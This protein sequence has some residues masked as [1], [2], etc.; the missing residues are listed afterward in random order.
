MTVAVVQEGGLG[1][2]QRDLSGVEH[3]EGSL[4]EVAFNPNWKKNGVEGRPQKVAG[5]GLSI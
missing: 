1:W 2:W 5:V 4:K 3:R